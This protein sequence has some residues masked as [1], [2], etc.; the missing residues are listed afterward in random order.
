MI[1]GVAL[2]YPDLGLLSIVILCVVGALVV[3]WLIDRYDK[4][5]N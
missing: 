3:L 5:S 4:S 1:D 2:V